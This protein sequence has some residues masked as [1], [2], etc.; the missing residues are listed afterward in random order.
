MKKFENNT[1]YE[2]ADDE[3]AAL[4]MTLEECLDNATDAQLEAI[5]DYAF[6]IAPV[7]YSEDADRKRIN[8][9]FDRAKKI[10]A[11]KVGAKLRTSGGCCILFYLFLR[12]AP[13]K[14]DIRYATGWS[15]ID[16]LP[17]KKLYYLIA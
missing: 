12:V 8:E 16:H 1:E 17:D 6:S 2:L 13:L 9:L 3:R 7:P 5:H 14:I 10:P 11:G 15:L 4:R